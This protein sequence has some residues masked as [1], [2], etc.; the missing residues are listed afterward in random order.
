MPFVNALLLNNKSEIGVIKA[1]Q[2]GV[3]MLAGGIFGCVCEK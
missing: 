3:C 2:G 1:C